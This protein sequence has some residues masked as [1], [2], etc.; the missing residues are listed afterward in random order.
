VFFGLLIYGNANDEPRAYSVAGGVAL[1]IV[2]FEIFFLVNAAVISFGWNNQFRYAW[3]YGI[4][5]MFVGLALMLSGVFIMWLHIEV[6]TSF[7]ILDTRLK[8]VEKE[9]RATQ[10]P[11]A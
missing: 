6:D 4:L 3:Q 11:E 9:L 2:F 1:L 5:V 7:Y 8:K 10:Q